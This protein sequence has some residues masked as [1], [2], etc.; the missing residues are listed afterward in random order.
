VPYGFTDGIF[1]G[2]MDDNTPIRLYQDT[3]QRMTNKPDRVWFMLM[4]AF[5]KVNV[6]QAHSGAANSRS[7]CSYNLESAKVLFEWFSISKA[8]FGTY[9]LWANQ[10]EIWSPIIKPEYEKYWYSLCFAF[11]LAENRCVVT[12]FE[13]DNP[14]VGAPEVFVDNPLC[15]ANPE[16]FWSTTLDK[17]IIA[18]PGAAIGLVNKIK[19]LYRHWN[20]QYCKGQWLYN[21]GLQNEPYFKYF[22]Y[23]DFLTPY[24][25][26]IQI[27]RYAE[28]E[29]LSDLQEL[30]RQISEL[31]KK[32]KQEIYRLLVEEF[33]YFE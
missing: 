5:S 26:L 25:G 28:Q 23:A 17:E 19:E 31:T 3:C 11:V 1:V 20:M 33:G 18:E 2:F 15:P 14:V 32:A 8:V 9:P 30:F 6:S 16:C 4:S 12:K 22:D 29:G 10:F 13:K 27:R 7:F 21:V 24:S